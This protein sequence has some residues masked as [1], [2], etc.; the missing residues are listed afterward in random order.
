LACFFFLLDWLIRAI[1]GKKRANFEEK[2]LIRKKNKTTKKDSFEEELKMACEGLYY[3]SETDAEIFPFFGGK[4][5]DGAREMVLKAAGLKK[6]E[7]VEERPFVQF[8][9]RLTKV[10]DWFTEI[11]TENTRR[12]LNLQNLLEDNLT[13]LTVLRIGRIQIDIYVV[14]ID[15][16]GN[17][18]GIRTKAIE[19]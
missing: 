5:T 12:F 15:K 4:V 6:K 19:T 1:L 9:E 13:D 16:A 2:I 11:E 10:R 14:G 3:V 8:F 18:V 17:L 7:K